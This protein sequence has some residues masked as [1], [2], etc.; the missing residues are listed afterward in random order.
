[1]SNLKKV[2]RTPDRKHESRES[3]EPDSSPE[4]QLSKIYLKAMPLRNLSDLESI[5]NEVVS[6]NILILKV[7]PLASKSIKDI[8]EAVNEL[9]E[10]AGKVKGDIARLGEERI[11][12]T[13]P[14]VGIWRERT[15]KSEEPVPT[16]A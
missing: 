14:G 4:E 1:M 9:C 3:P 15:V 13:P 7:T 8:K 10:F 2:G 6:G 11:V 5:K 12:I 16:A